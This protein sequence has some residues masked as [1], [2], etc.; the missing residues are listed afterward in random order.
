MVSG[1]FYIDQSVIIYLA[2]FKFVTTEGGERPTP[3]NSRPVVDG[4]ECGRGSLVFFNQSTMFQSSETGYNTLIAAG[5]A[6]HS[7]ES[8][9]IQM[10]NQAFTNVKTVVPDVFK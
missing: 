3:E 4:D 5:E 2:D 9:A 10:A 1:S 6:G 8:D 7:R